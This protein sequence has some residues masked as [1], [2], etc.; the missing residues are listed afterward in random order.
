MT[1][2]PNTEDLQFLSLGDGTAMGFAFGLV[3]RGEW[4]FEVKQAMNRHHYLSLTGHDKQVS[5]PSISNDDSSKSYSYRL[6]SKVLK[7]MEGLSAHDAAEML[8]EINIENYQE[9]WAILERMSVDKAFRSDVMKQYNK[10]SDSCGNRRHIEERSDLEKRS[11]EEVK[12]T[13]RAIIDEN[14]SNS[15]QRGQSIGFPPLSFFSWLLKR[16]WKD[17]SVVNSTHTE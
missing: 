6:N 1:Y 13:D 8:M 7:E 17:D 2:E 14:N 12:P 4:V 11:L 15:N 9:A 16:S 10:L 5:A 3:L